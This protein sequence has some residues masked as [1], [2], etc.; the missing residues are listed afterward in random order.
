MA[1]TRQH[2]GCRL[3]DMLRRRVVIATGADSEQ[4]LQLRATVASLHKIER[5]RKIMV[6]DMGLT[7]WEMDQVKKTYADVC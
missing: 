7:A 1:F 3:C 4:F 6:F 2:S 5:K